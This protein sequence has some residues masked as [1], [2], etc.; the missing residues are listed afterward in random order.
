MRSKLVR[1]R[2]RAKLLNHRIESKLR[3]LIIK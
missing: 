2:S 3:R 1:V